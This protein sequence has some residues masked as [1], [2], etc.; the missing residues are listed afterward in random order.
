MDIYVLAYTYYE[1]TKDNDDGYE[2][3]VV[4]LGAH[5]TKQRALER[6]Q[7]HYAQMIESG[8]YSAGDDEPDWDGLFSGGSGD[9]ADSDMYQIQSF[10]FR[11]V[12]GDGDE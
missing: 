9:I 7:R 4:F 5:R 6:A 11:T 8:I 1:E 3:K 2:G 10:N 12:L